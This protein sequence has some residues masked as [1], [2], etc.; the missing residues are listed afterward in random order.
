[1][2]A[3]AIIQFKYSKWVQNKNRQSYKILCST[4]KVFYFNTSRNTQNFK[5]KFEASERRR[6]KQ[7]KSQ[8][9]INSSLITSVIKN[10]QIIGNNVN[11]GCTYKESKRQVSSCTQKLQGFLSQNQFTY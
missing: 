11:L 4:L 1:M 7:A 2:K 3:K 6:Q 9:T 8:K 5:N 10:Q